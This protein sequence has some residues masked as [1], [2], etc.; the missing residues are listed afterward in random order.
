MNKCMS[1]FQ[2]QRIKKKKRKQNK[3]DESFLE[4]KLQG[5]LRLKSQGT[6]LMSL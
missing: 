1:E 2:V 5:M 4:R 6:N 3:T